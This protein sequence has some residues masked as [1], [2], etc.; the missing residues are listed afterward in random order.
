MPVFLDTNIIV[1]AFTDDPRAVVAERLL[2]DGGEISVQV[3]NEFA[4]VAQRKLGFD[5]QRLAEALGIVRTL[6]TKIH[7]VDLACHIEAMAIAERSGVSIYDGLIVASAL[8]A[9]CD[10]LYSEDMHDGLKI[11]AGLKIVNPF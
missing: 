9:G 6:A 3:L 8:G 2:A 1:Y 4:N 5:W 7:A 11:G 10:T